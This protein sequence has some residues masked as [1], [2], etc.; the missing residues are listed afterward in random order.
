[1][2]MPACSHGPSTEQVAQKHQ[3]KIT[4]VN[5]WFNM[6]LLLSDGSLRNRRPATER[7]V[8]DKLYQRVSH[9][10]GANFMGKAIAIFFAGAALIVLAGFALAP[11]TVA[12]IN[13]KCSPAYGIDPCNTEL[14]ASIPTK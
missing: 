14:T 1:M 10:L 6:F 3:I 11:S 13:S 9:I 4:A 12:A 2:K 5:R 8:F 7:A